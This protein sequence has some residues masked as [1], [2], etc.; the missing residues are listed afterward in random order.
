[1]VTHSALL[2]GISSV[3]KKGNM[4][5]TGRMILTADESM[6]GTVS[7]I[8]GL[9]IATG[10]AGMTAGVVAMTAGLTGSGVM[11]AGTE[12]VLMTVVTGSATMTEAKIGV[13]ELAAAEVAAEAAAD[14][15][16]GMLV[17]CSGT[18]Q[19]GMC[20]LLRLMFAAGMVMPAGSW[21]WG[22]TPA[23]GGL[24]KKCSGLEA[25]GIDSCM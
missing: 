11:T 22:P 4:T 25:V 13:I 17:M 12:N 21:T 1:M 8:T 24:L 19:Q 7:A 20:Q 3:K 14:Q 5:G 2:S 10:S 15:R 6:N 9:M 18:E 16:V 23:A